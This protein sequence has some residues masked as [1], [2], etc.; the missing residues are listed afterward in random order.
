MILYYEEVEVLKLYF[1][2]EVQTR[3]SFQK[4]RKAKVIEINVNEM[5]LKSIVQTQML[6]LLLL[7]LLE[8]LQERPLLLPLLNC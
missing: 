3:S 1:S 8:L 4:L 2:F 7:L 5:K 6:L